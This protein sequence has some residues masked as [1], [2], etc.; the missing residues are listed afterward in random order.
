MTNERDYQALDELLK[1]ASQVVDTF[2]QPLIRLHN[3]VSLRS[4]AEPAIHIMGQK[5]GYAQLYYGSDG[6]SAVVSNCIELGNAWEDG[7]YDYPEYGFDVKDGKLIANTHVGR[8]ELLRLFP[9]LMVKTLE[10]K[11][12]QRI[13]KSRRLIEK[14]TR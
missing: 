8:M 5:R 1:E 4:L 13:E 6:F 7:T 2:Y 10:G 11:L 12:V 9:K 3:D 14:R